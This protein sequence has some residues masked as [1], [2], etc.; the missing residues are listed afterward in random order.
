MRCILM[1]CVMAAADVMD[2]I[3]QVK[4]RKGAVSTEEMED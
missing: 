1:R 3:Y 2:G 4:E